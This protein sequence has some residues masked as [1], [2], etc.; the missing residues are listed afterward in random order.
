MRIT[1]GKYKTRSLL[2]KREPGVRPSTS[3][4]RQAVFNILGNDLTGLSF[5][6][7]F[8]GS[9]IMGLE[10]LSRGAGPVTFIDSNRH[11]IQALRQNLE[12]FG[13]PDHDSRLI[14]SPM[15]KALESLPQEA[16]DLIY[17][18]PPF[19]EA[20]QTATVLVYQQLTETIARV[21]LLRKEG[22]LI[23]EHPGGDPPTL[24]RGP[25]Q[26]VDQRRYGRVG[27]QFLRY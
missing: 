11:C 7:G 20:R 19:A 2:G 13:V 3:R 4:N 16:F 1:G 6:D 25:Y 27:I 10:A 9:G 18:D 14:T 21:G 8:C 12:V 15:I 24:Q 17:L 23:L 26:V 22:M 5:L